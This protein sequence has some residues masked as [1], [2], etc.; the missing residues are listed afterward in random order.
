MSLVWEKAC[1]QFSLDTIQ[2]AT[3]YF[4]ESRIIGKGGFGSVYKGSVVDGSTM[5]LVAVKRLN[6]ESKQGGGEF[7][8][9]IKML[10]KCRH[11]HVVSLLGYCNERQEMILV[12]EYMSN[13]TLADH[14]Y[15]NHDSSLMW[16]RRVK[17]CIGAA[18]GLDYLHTGT[19]LSDRVIHL[20]VKGANILLD[21]NW[22]AKIA[23]LGLS[24]I[25]PANQTYSEVKTDH[26]RGTRGYIDPHYRKNGKFTRKSDVY[27]FGVVLLEVL[28]GT[29][30][31]DGKIIPDQGLTDL[32]NWIQQHISSRTLSQIIDRRVLSEITPDCLKHFANITRKSLHNDPKKRPSM[33]EVVAQLEA[34]LDCQLQTNPSSSIVEVDVFQHFNANTSQIELETTSENISS[35]NHGVSADYLGRARCVFGTPITKKMMIKRGLHT[36]REIRAQVAFDT[37]NADNKYD[38]ALRFVKDLKDQWGDEISM[39]CLIYNAT[40]ETLTHIKRHNWFG[41]IGPSPVTKV[42]LNGQWGAYVHPKVPL[43]SSGSAGAEVYR[44]KYRD[45]VHGAFCDHMISWYIPGQRLTQGNACY[46]EINEVGHYEGDV[47]DAIYERTLYAGRESSTNWKECSIGAMIESDTSPIYRAMFTR[48]DIVVARV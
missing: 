37:R 4:N 20:D 39:L 35:E 34:A 44:G 41:D 25:G 30:A 47:W 26:I 9:E 14:L 48:V 45:S 19:G 11:C 5:T 7:E 36:T 6:P 1:Q 2:Q 15:K 28:S 31:L 22:A 17:I 8:T 18:R 10:S 43:V 23:D 40:G 3:D 32:A 42:I 27:A 29:G 21:E 38:N 12:Y 13:G 46:C 16:E 24:K 33:S